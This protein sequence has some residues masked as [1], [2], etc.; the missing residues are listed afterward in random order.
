MGPCLCS[1]G[2]F[3]R[4]AYRSLASIEASEWLTGAEM[5][6]SSTNAVPIQG[7]C[8]YS[9]RF[10]QKLANRD[11]PIQYQLRSKTLNWHRFMIVRVPPLKIS[12]GTSRPMR[13]QHFELSTNQKPRFRP[14]SRCWPNLESTNPTP[15][16]QWTG[17]QVP[18]ECQLTADW[19]TLYWHWTTNGMSMGYQWND[20]WIPMECQL[21]ANGMQFE[22][23]I[24]VSLIC[25]CNVNQIH[26]I[27]CQCNVNLI[28]WI[29]GTLSIVEDLTQVWLL[30]RFPIYR[31]TT[32]EPDLRLTNLI[33]MQCQS[34]SWNPMP[35]QSNSLVQLA[36]DRSI[37][38][39][40]VSSHLEVR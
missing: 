4:L 21:N 14:D 18:L 36:Q 35:M 25:Q 19:Q 32:E 16:C 15:M 5:N 11:E 13:S 20:N 40:I 34:N 7:P 31:E 27:Q 30:G 2:F 8:L 39:H 23:H 3:W 28:H 26:W 38:T 37:C 22:D 1:T 24:G 10:I 17:N 29:H 33:P 9:T 12:W 6:Q